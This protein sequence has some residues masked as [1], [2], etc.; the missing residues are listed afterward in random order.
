MYSNTQHV[1]HHV[2]MFRI[3]ALANPTRKPA[4]RTECEKPSDVTVVKVH[5]DSLTIDHVKV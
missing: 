3:A 2:S 4:W 5:G 1:M